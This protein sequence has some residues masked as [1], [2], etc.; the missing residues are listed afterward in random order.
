MEVKAV[1][2]LET[3]EGGKVSVPWNDME[4]LYDVSGPK[5]IWEAML[6]G[7]M[8]KVGEYPKESEVEALWDK[9]DEVEDIAC[10]LEALND[11]EDIEGL[12]VEDGYGHDV[13]KAEMA[14]SNSVPYEET[15]PPMD[16]LK[17]FDDLVFDSQ[18]FYGDRA[19]IHFPNGYG[20]SVLKEEVPDLY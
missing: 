6:F 15:L 16:A 9:L 10:A 7:Y 17:T 20:V 14:Y 8:T 12:V 2:V 13:L 1:V 18:S 19:E 11:D 3:V 4:A 5:E